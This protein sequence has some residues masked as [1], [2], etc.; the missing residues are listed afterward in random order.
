ML[1][2]IHI[3]NICLYNVCTYMYLYSLIMTTKLP[4]FFPEH[5][6]Q[7]ILLQCICVSFTSSSTLIIFLFT[8]NIWQANHVSLKFSFN[9]EQ[10]FIA[11][12][13][14][15]LPLIEQDFPVREISTLLSMSV[16]GSRNSPSVEDIACKASAWVPNGPSSL[17]LELRN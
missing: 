14:F 16:K 12:C 17:I 6:Y 8:F 15:H 7:F 3:Y 5:V 9:T 2:R 4:N 1:T 10:M 11:C 13:I